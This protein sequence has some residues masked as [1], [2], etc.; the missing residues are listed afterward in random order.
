M[1]DAEYQLLRLCNM[2]LGL[3]DPLPF[4]SSTAALSSRIEGKAAL[5]SFS[6]GPKALRATPTC[7]QPCNMPY[8]SRTSFHDYFSWLPLCFLRKQ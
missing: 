5:I 8:D 6:V 4:L 7:S 2:L 1:Q 3:P